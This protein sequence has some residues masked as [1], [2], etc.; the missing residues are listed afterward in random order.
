MAI[1][2]QRLYNEEGK[3]ECQKRQKIEVFS[4]P[5]DEKHYEFSKNLL[6][7][8]SETQNAANGTSKQYRQS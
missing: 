1:F 7:Q 6:N 3:K 4:D 8:H 2:Y 5:F